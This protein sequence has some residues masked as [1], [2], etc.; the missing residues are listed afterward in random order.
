MRLIEM[1]VKRGKNKVGQVE[2]AEVLIKA[3]THTK[4]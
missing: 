4:P 3:A 2:I 1:V